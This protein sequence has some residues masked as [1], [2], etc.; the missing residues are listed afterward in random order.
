MKRKNR[1]DRWLE[2]HLPVGRLASREGKTMLALLMGA[3]I[4]AAVWYTIV[5]TAARRELY[6]RVQGE[7]VL[8]YQVRMADFAQIFPI[9]PLGFWLVVIIMPM[10]VWDYYLYHHKQSKSIYLMRRLGDPNELRRRCWTV[11]LCTAV[12][13]LLLAAGTT[14]LCY[15]I[16]MTCTPASAIV[17]GQWERFWRMGIGG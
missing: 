15:W 12:L 6:V 1:L 7:L 16:Y 17:P 14:A 3:I 5:Y 10:K 2:D 8:G 13:S 11:P 9:V 4:W